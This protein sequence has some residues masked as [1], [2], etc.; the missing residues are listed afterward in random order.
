[1]EQPEYQDNIPP[2]PSNIDNWLI[3][4]VK[5][6]DSHK[7]FGFIV[8][9]SLGICGHTKGVNKL[10]DLYVKR[11]Y[12]QKGSH[13]N[14]D[15]KVIFIPSKDKKRAYYVKN[16]KYNWNTLM[17]A[18]KYRGKYSKIEGYDVHSIYN[19]KL[20]V[21][22]DILNHY[23]KNKLEEI[24]DAFCEYLFKLSSDDVDLTISQFLGNRELVKTLLPI[25]IKSEKRY[26]EKPSNEVFTRFKRCIEEKYLFNADLEAIRILPENFNYTL[27]NNT[28]IDILIKELY[29]ELSNRSCFESIV[30]D[31]KGIITK[32]NFESLSTEDVNTI[33]LRIILCHLTR[34]QK[35]IT[36][37]NVNWLN[38]GIYL[39]R[40]NRSVT[41]EY[42]K[43]FF[44][45][46]DE[47]FFSNHPIENV[48]SAQNAIFLLKD[49]INNTHYNVLQ[50]KLFSIV[51]ENDI[52]L[53]SELPLY[54]LEN[55]ISDNDF[56][57]IVIIKSQSQLSKITITKY[58]SDSEKSK[59]LDI[60]NS[61]INLKENESDQITNAV[62]SNLKEDTMD[63]VK[64]F[65]YKNDYLHVIDENFI[66]YYQEKFSIEEMLKLLSSSK[67]TEQQIFKIS[68][69]YMKML[70][71]KGKDFQQSQL[72]HF[73][74]TNYNSKINEWE[75]QWTLPFTETEKYEL[76]KK[77]IIIKDYSYYLFDNLLDGNVANYKTMF[78]IDV[79]TK[80]RI[81]NGLIDN[82]KKVNEIND[83]TTFNKVLYHI[84]SIIKN[85]TKDSVLVE[86]LSNPV[87]NLFLWYFGKTD[88]V[89]F[90][91]LKA[92]FIYFAPKYQ[93]KII[94]KL[95]RQIELKK[96]TISI[97]MLNSLIRVDRDLFEVI[98][99]EKPTIPIDISV[100]IVLKSLYHYYKEH[101][102]YYDKEIYDIILF[103]LSL[104]MGKY[105]SYHFKLDE[106]FDKCDGRKYYVERT[107]I[108]YVTGEVI[109]NNN[110][111]EIQIYSCYYITKAK[112]NYYRVEYSTDGKRI[113]QPV[114]I[115]VRKKNEYFSTI[116]NVVKSLNGI[117][118]DNNK[119]KWLVHIDGN[120]ITEIKRI[121]YQ[122]N[123]VIKGDNEKVIGEL[124]SIPKE[125]KYQ[126]TKT[127]QR[128]GIVFCEGRSVENKWEN[129]N[130]KSFYW[131]GN[132]MCF[133]HQ[134]VEH[135]D[136]DWEKYTMF[137][138]CRILGFNTD[139]SDTHGRLV[140]NG[141]YLVFV[142]V[143]NRMN[144][145]L[146]HLKCKS[147]GELLEPAS[148]SNYLTHMVTR[149]KCTTHNCPEYGNVYYISKCFNWKCYGII[150]QRETK[151]CPNGWFICK[152]CG[153][154]CSN[155]IV[156][157][158]L[159]NCKVLNIP[160]S[161]Y[162]TDFA[163]KK[164]GHLEKRE[165][166]C[167]KCGEK[168]ENYKCKNCQV[169]YERWKYDCL[170]F[171]ISTDY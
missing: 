23:D 73:I 106:F 83:L 76:W 61:F 44:A 139:K 35:Y 138:F 169:S 85:D 149:F 45:D 37:I 140:K 136:G 102:F 93:V 105:K 65:L 33:P 25:I 13:I 68:V 79:L 96:I 51:L 80:E 77:K 147:C 14:D 82:L 114:L 88:N 39:K 24:V 160:Q 40:I 31:L 155:R 81:S 120:S 167:Y 3:G 97:E 54:Y 72:K 154:C 28:I 132:A 36:E 144:Y 56:V 84:Y 112:R 29:H 55:K 171:N 26:N 156:E 41:I 27:Y 91:T 90:E 134:V 48:I 146:E 162:L 94:K 60:F 99:K 153:S 34:N 63:I 10:Y 124:K 127:S 137:D 74:I 151:R 108:P 20:N 126:I 21:L 38:I 145:M 8:T 122:Y 166:Y 52:N 12:I 4:I 59:I 19:Y 121:A 141:E 2:K 70:T 1:M 78:D 5:F 142:S 130:G 15:D 168:T 67:L 103:N 66:I 109:V 30:T 157:Q 123:M 100:D 170:D 150:D 158:R 128:Q 89:D 7:G 129:G 50:E 119:E 143:I 107:P 46:K 22:L 16:I 104:N 6:Y 62:L 17:L 95:F 116:N 57:E 11:Q 125:Y 135:N 117:Q 71:N 161:E 118:L 9:N 148:I 152:V 32:I 64:V 115:E 113:K 42:F 159:E 92:K 47:C 164:L 75:D 165:F 43:V 133:E 110:E 111:F 49:I 163:F 86:G 18:M 101:K 131:C 87:F 58:L 69:A 98:A 53:L